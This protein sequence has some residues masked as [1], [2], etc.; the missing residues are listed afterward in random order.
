M[1]ESND[2][3]PYKPNKETLI[4]MAQTMGLR[5]QASPADLD[6]YC[7]WSEFWSCAGLYDPVEGA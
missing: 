7:A 5:A 6:R 2:K 3:W 1:S 4:S